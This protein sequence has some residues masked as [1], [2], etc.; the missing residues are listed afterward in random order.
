MKLLA[1]SIASILSLLFSSS[2]FADDLEQSL[3]SQIGE[4]HKSEISLFYQIP[5]T[6]LRM[7]YYVPPALAAILDSHTEEELLPALTSLRASVEASDSL[8]VQ[9]WIAI[10]KSRVRGTTS[11]VDV[12]SGSSVKHVPVVLYSLPLHS[13]LP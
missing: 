9:S 1:L 3:R 10:A 12:P 13:H 5:F 2:S 4:V 8:L 6:S 7:Y 11:A